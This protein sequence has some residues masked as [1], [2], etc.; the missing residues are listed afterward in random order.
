MF[1]PDV[2]AKLRGHLKLG[3]DVPDEQVA[4]VAVEHVSAA[5][6]V[7][8]KARADAQRVTSLSADVKRLNDELKSEREKVTALS[9]DAP[10]E[11]DPRMLGMIR[12][13]C[14]NAR[15]QV[16]ASGVVSSAGMDKI[17]GLLGVTAPDGIALSLS[18]DNPDEVIYTSLCDI[19]AAHPGIKTNAAIN[20][21]RV[22]LSAGRED[23]ELTPERKRELLKETPLGQSALAA[24]K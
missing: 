19:L 14:K 9:A 12:K 8:E 6:D 7:Q 3:D 2:I 23:A 24:A 4:T 22:S 1:R 18:A 17:D 5:I 16:I 13:T 15:D 21:P 10:K 11:L 20:R